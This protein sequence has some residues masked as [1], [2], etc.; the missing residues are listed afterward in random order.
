MNQRKE[1]SIFQKLNLNKVKKGEEF[2]KI[3]VLSYSTAQNQQIPKMFTE[4]PFKKFPL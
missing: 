4:I 3:L 2:F 1:D